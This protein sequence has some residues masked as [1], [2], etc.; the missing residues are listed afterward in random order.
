[1]P[2]ERNSGYLAYAV[3]GVLYVAVLSSVVGGSFY[4]RSWAISVYGSP[5]AQ[6]Q[7]D[8]WRAGAAKLSTEGPVKRRVPKSDKL[9]ELKVDLGEPEL[10]TILA[11]IGEHYAPEALVGR[12]IAVVANLA[13]RTFA[14]FGK[15]SHGMVLAVSDANGLSVLSPDKEISQGVRLK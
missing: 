13:P 2:A 5:E 8:E 12:R 1:M 9:L 15:T 14:K 7:W 6:A 4:A 3:Y 11:G 10:R